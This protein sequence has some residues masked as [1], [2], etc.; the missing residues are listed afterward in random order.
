MVKKILIVLFFAILLFGLAVFQSG[1]KLNSQLILIALGVCAS[2]SIW[3]KFKSFQNFLLNMLV[4]IGSY[5]ALFLLSTG[6]LDL[7][8][9]NRASVVVDGETYKVMDWTWVSVMLV[10][11]VGAVVLTLLYHYKLKKHGR[12]FE[13]YYAAGFVGV[14]AMGLVMG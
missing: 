12:A 10:G 1:L 4:L 2:L 5:T 9:P 6:I 3:F 8:D 7:L 11:I 14:C 13:L